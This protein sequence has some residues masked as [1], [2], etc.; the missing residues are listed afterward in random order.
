MRKLFLLLILFLFSQSIAFSQ[1][2]RYLRKAAHATDNGRLDK[3]RE[4][5]LK[6]LAIDKD[7]YNANVGFGVTLSEFMDQP[8]EALPYLQ[9]AYRHTPK[10]TFPLYALAKCYQHFGNFTESIKF[11]D[12]LKGAVALDEDDKLF[13]LDLK[14]RR[15]D[16]V[17]VLRYHQR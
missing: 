10:D 6:A 8:E 4:Y 1:I 2:K 16:C 15:E 17:Y 13:Q 5:Y 3:A 9:N 14:K 11:L 12:M 7:N